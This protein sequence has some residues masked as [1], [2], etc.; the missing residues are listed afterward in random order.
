MNVYKVW[1][2]DGSSEEASASVEAYVSSDAVQLF[3]EQEYISPKD[4]GTKFE[5]CVRSADEPVEVFD[6][7]VEF[8][9]EFCIF[10]KTP[11]EE[12]PPET[13]K[14]DHGVVFP[15]DVDENMSVEEVRRRYPRLF[16]PCPEGCG[17]SG[18]AYASYL[19]YVMG[20]W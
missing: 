19:H 7:E 18:I 2:R 1:W 3:C 9:P 4:H 8:S 5:V 12:A 14:C 10:A 15:D 17:F 11:P 6:V 20:D 13:P 16:G